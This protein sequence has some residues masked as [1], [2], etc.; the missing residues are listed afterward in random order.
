MILSVQTAM[1]VA[2]CHCVVSPCLCGAPGIVLERSCKPVDDG[3]SRMYCRAGGA[4]ASTS[5]IFLRHC[6]LLLP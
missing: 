4:S 3:P 2:P 5:A 1:M 6:R